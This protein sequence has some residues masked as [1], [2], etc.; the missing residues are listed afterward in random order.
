MRGAVAVAAAV[1]LCAL[2]G[3]TAGESTVPRRPAYPRV[4]A[5]DT[6]PQTVDGLPVFFE[7][8]RSARVGRPSDNWLDV[9]YPMYGA[10][11]HVTFTAAS[12]E[13]LDE[14]RANRMERAL[15]NAGGLPTG[16][17]EWRNP[18]GF[19]IMTMRTDGCSTPFQFLATDGRGMVVSGA[20]Y[21][22]S[23]RAVLE[24]DSIAPMLDAMEA[25]LT[26]ALGRM[27]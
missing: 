27:R 20:V 23:P 10:T 9:A 6:V 14:V 1:V 7:V 3:C 19:D 8:S 13:E 18:A 26:R 11:A 15:L 21:F 24:T 2:A 12:G 16:R 22:A 4:A 25:D 5:L 17:R